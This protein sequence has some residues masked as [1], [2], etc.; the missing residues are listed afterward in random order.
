MNVKMTQNYVL[1]LPLK[2]E[3]KGL[4]IVPEVDNKKATVYCV[5]ADCKQVKEKDIVMYN[6]YIKGSI[7]IDSKLFVIVKEDDV[8]CILD[9]P[10]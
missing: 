2:D 10:D 3:K 5:G 7:E 8:F 6:G 4:L 1:L 9:R